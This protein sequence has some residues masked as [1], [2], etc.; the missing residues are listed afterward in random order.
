MNLRLLEIV[1]K[2][3][4]YSICEFYEFKLLRVKRRSGKW[5]IFD[6]VGEIDRMWEII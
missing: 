4:I 5:L 3:W 1:D 6:S 2:Y